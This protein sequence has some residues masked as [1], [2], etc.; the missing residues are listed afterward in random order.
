MPFEK[1]AVDAFIVGHV[2]GST[3]VR[4]YNQMGGR[5]HGVVDDDVVLENLSYTDLLAGELELVFLFVVD[6]KN[7]LFLH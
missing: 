5:N 1:R 2:Q 6:Q 7:K 4:G 3:L